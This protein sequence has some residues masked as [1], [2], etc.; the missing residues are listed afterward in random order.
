M[1]DTKTLVEVKNLKEY[2][3]INTGMFTSKP[4]K[5]VDDVSFEIMKGEVFGLVGES[6]CGKTTLGRAILK[7]HQPTAGQI[8]LNGKSR[9]IETAN[10]GD[11]VTNVVL[12]STSNSYGKSFSSLQSLSQED[13]V[14]IL[15]EPKNA[16]TKQ[17]EALLQMDGV[18]LEIQPEALKIIAQKALDRQ[19]GARGLRAIMEKVMTKVMFVIPSDLSIKKVIITPESVEGADPTIIRDPAHPREKLTGRRN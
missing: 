18:A 9:G 17:Y 19:I 3:N 10:M 6:G 1:S 14:R 4:L 2:F 13:L 16:L 7:L 12:R 11:R 5:A 15:V 8:I